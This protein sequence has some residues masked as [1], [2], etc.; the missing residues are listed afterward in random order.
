MGLSLRRLEVTCGRPLLHKMSFRKGRMALDSVCHLLFAKKDREM[1]F[2]A[3]VMQREAHLPE[4]GAG[5][6]FKLTLRGEELWGCKKGRRPRTSVAPERCLVFGHY[7]KDR[8]VPGGLP[9]ASVPNV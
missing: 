7:Q 2:D 3:V 9:I 8:S 4:D 6:S 1:N 5:E